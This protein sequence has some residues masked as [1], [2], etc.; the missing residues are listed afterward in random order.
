MRPAGG[1]RDA[2][3]AEA[4]AAVVHVDP[5]DGSAGIF[6]DA[7]VV[8]RLAQPI[9]R[10]SLDATSFSVQDAHGP[11]PGR[12]RLVGQGDVVVWNA[13]RPLR[14]DELHFVIVSG[15]RDARGREVPRHLSRFVPCAFS[16][17]D[18]ARA[19]E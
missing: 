11:V 16:S 18:V 12:L 2:A 15:L 14:A 13:E 8:V 5:G 7:P 6:C 1:A 3:R 9:D 4:R 10:S 19:G 17:C